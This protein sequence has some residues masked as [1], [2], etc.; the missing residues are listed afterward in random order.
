MP[1]RSCKSSGKSGHKYG[2]K[3]KCYTGS[4][5]KSKAKRQGRAIQANKKRKQFLFVSKAIAIFSWN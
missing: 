1:V 4:G 2:S 5:S 3:G